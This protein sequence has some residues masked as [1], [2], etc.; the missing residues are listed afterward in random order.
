[1]GVAQSAKPE[2]RLC[3]GYSKIGRKSTTSLARNNEIMTGVILK[4]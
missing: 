1:M 2:V 3:P 4:P